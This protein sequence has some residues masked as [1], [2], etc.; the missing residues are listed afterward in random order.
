MKRAIT[1]FDT[2]QNDNGEPACGRQVY[3]PIGRLHLYQQKNKI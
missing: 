1:N 2:Q 3:L